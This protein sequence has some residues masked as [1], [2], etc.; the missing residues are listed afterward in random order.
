[1]LV[2]GKLGESAIIISFG[3]AKNF[4]LKCVTVVPIKQNTRFSF[5]LD[6]L[7]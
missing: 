3:H 7:K 4:N 2:G 6:K 1:M 5:F